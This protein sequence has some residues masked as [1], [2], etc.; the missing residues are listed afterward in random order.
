MLV[1]EVDAVE[2]NGSNLIVTD[3]EP[4][5]AAAHQKAVDARGMDQRDD[6]GVADTAD[7]PASDHQT[8]S[9]SSSVKKRSDSAI[10]NVRA[11][12]LARARHGR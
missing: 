4:G 10:G 9:P 8:G 2:R 3:G 11:H 12:N 7:A 5:P 1:A 6:G